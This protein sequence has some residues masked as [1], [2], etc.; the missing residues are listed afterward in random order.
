MT[1]VRT[2]GGEG[3][4]F[5]TNCINFEAGLILSFR[6]RRQ[7]LLLSTA[8]VALAW[9]A[10][11]A[12]PAA[13]QTVP[14][15]ITID[16]AKNDVSPSPASSP[17]W[18]TGG[19][20]LWVGN[21]SDAEITVGA[22]GSLTSYQSFLGIGAGS[23]GK[24]TVAD[25]GTWTTAGQAQFGVAGHGELVIGA[26]S[27]VTNGFGVVGSLA[28]STGMVTVEGA[29]AT[30]NN[31]PLYVGYLGRGSVRVGAGGTVV[32]T[33]GGIA[34]FAGS[35]GEMM[36][37]GANALFTV[38]D[39]LYV[40][41]GGTGTLT[42][43]NGGRVTA[44]T[45]DIGLDPLTTNGT[46]NVSGR[47]GAG[48]ASSLAVAG[49][50]IVGEE[51]VGTL[52][53]SDGGQVTSGSGTIGRLAAATG[54]ATITG[55]G[56]GGAAW[57]LAGE[58]TVGDAGSG[59]LQ[60]LQGGRVASGSGRIGAA[61][62]GA[63]NV[64]VSGSDGAGTASA[65]TLAGDLVVGD[66]GTGSLAVA[67]GNRVQVGGSTRLAVAAGSRGTISLAG[68]AAGPAVLEPGAVIAGA[69]T[70]TVT[71]DYGLL[72]ASRSEARFLD[73]A[74]QV[75][76]GPGGGWIDTAGHDLAASARFSGSG[77]LTLQGG[78]RLVL[79]GDSSA[80][81]GSTTIAA[82]TLQIGDGG[83][84]GMLGGSIA[85]NGEIGFNRADTVT[86]GGTIAGGGRLRQAG[87]GTTI[88]AGSNSYS[89][90]TV[91][92]RGTL[93]GSAASFGSGA[94][95]NNGNLV[96]DQG[97]DAIFANAVDGSGSF[98][99]Q[100]AGALNYTG[101][102]GLSGPTVVAQGLL[103]V[104]GALPNS[105]VTVAGGA[106]LGGAGT[107]GATRVSGGGS[108]APGNSIGTLQVN[109]AYVQEPGST[110]RVEVDPGSNASDL[111]LVEGPATIAPGAILA[112]SK[113]PPGEYRPDAAYTVL[114][115]SGGV[116][117]SYDLTGDLAVSPYLA[118]AQQLDANNVYLR[119]VR[120]ADPSDAAQTPNQ[121]ETAAGA[122][123]LPDSS[124]VGSAL[125]NTQTAAATR[126]ALDQLSGE[127]LASARSALVAGSQRLR[128][129]ALA[130]LGG[131]SCSPAAEEAAQPDR[132]PSAFC[133]PDPERPALWAQA[134]GRRGR[135]SSDGNAAGMKDSTA[136][137]LL[138]VD[139]PVRDWRVGLFGGYSRTD[140][141]IDDR[142]ASG[143]ADSY[144]LGLHAGTRWEG[145]GL[146]LRLG[147]SH[148][149]HRVAT[150][151][152]VSVGTL[153]NGLHA[154]F[155]AR[156]SQAFAEL[157]RRFELGR[158]AVEPFAGLA[159]VRLETDGFSE[160]GGGAALTAQSDSMDTSFSTLGIRAATGIARGSVDLRLH[161]MAGWRHAFGDTVPRSSVSFAGGSG[162]TIAGT[163]IARDAA[164]VEAGLD[165]AVSRDVRA[166]IAYDGQISRSETGHTIRAGVSIAF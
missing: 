118:L 165:M 141:D 44:A 101:S 140:F 66:A 153:A 114:T 144:H 72:R 108:I 25:G 94:I 95:V 70:A 74:M 82:G 20:Q 37:D 61:A 129:A 38:T 109:G 49:A 43:V 45:A 73:G 92:D 158:I 12:R 146:A 67:G 120:T 21:N 111:I 162:F 53:V 6:I 41:W 122:D 80:F 113:N 71:L 64:T 62:T 143:D 93:V 11:G 105:A 97:Q 125:L 10:G 150:D 2:A 88:L 76:V 127:I 142:A 151:R 7:A 16:P 104:N 91:I 152:S 83:T 87:T 139:A 135:F 19:A 48:T 63:G 157:G 86:F 8:I 52:A 65:W 36:V 4:V 18:D 13:A 164:L 54:T 98:V 14:P 112:V 163:P 89:G 58:L 26:G 123:S 23:S 147:T 32:T 121:Q 148:S 84:T 116:S 33:I 96:L 27:T 77:A 24:V 128:D 131:L 34:A 30:W 161:G 3:E 159:H 132:R 107:V 115:A 134:I 31:A 90:G 149:W 79:T 130:R 68:G 78:G 156:T 22:G 133:P 102:G 160:S 110:Y 15:G 117:G 145:P 35:T 50:L 69:G 55:G 42:I 137:I 103:A 85:N 5:R 59:S 154:G 126:G 138:G 56:S 47:D 136:G 17:V 51:S 28:G 155:D 99:K 75:A 166:G 81:A 100:G 29:G 9:A 57:T 1:V 119:V 40:G 106:V 39:A 124:A 46:I 60:V